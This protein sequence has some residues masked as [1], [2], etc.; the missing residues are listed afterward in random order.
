[1]KQEREVLGSLSNDAMNGLVVISKIVRAKAEQ[2]LQHPVSAD[3]A[4]DL[5]NRHGW[6]K[7]SPRTRHPKSTPEIQEEFKKNFQN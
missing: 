5:L 3:Y 6:R 7:V 2:I 1:M 4:E